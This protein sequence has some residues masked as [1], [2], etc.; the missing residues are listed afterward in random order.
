MFESFQFANVVNHFVKTQSK[1]AINKGYTF[2]PY[3][4]SN[5]EN[6]QLIYQYVSENVINIVLTLSTEDEIDEMITNIT[7][8]VNKIPI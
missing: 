4:L 7:K 8:D 6:N 5:F 3:Q 1:I 2:N